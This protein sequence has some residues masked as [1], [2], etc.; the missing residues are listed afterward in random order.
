MSNKHIS[1]NGATIDADSL[2]KFN[3]E[4]MRI[5]GEIEALDEEFKDLINRAKQETKIKKGDISQYFRSR[6]KA[7]T[8]NVIEQGELFSTLNK[9]VDGE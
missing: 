4:A 9:A 6:F 8:K 5:Q 7:K 3:A 1:I 2:K